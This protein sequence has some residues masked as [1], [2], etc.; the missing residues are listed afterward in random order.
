MPRAGLH[1]ACE[2][3]CPA[4]RLANRFPTD[5]CAASMAA[6]IAENLVAGSHSLKLRLGDDC[7]AI[8]GGSICNRVNNRQLRD[9]NRFQ[10]TEK[11]KYFKCF[12]VSGIYTHVRCSEMLP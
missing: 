9:P 4:R 3:V 10:R 8:L 2:T 5:G 1:R 12:Q 11:V 6:N 7:Q